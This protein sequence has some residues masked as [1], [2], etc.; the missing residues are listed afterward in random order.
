[1]ILD[2]AT[3]SIDVRSEQV[4]QAA[5][6]RVS[7]NRTT[8]TIAHRLSTIKKADNIVVLTKGAAVQQGTHESL[9][10]QV[11]GAYWT[12]AT[13]QQLSMDEE[14]LEG[15]ELGEKTRSMDIMESEEGTSSAPPDTSPDAPQKWVARGF[16]RSFGT[17][18][19]EQGRHWPW[20]TMLLFGAVI[21]GG[22]LNP[23]PLTIAVN[24]QGLTN[25]SQQRAPQRRLSFSPSLSLDSISLETSC[26][27]GSISGVSCSPCW[28]A[29]SA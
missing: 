9:M 27:T 5:L 6:D 10:A 14:P 29:Q 4:V 3:S 22:Q 2:E 7:V 21:A 11:G 15:S 17:L 12:L 1:L 18:I 20:Y 28:L 26:E 19:V 24:V 8:I 13:S 16:F 25:M 23:I